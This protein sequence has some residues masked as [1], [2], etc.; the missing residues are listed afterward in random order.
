MEL[1]GESN[2]G[3]RALDASG[4]GRRKGIVPV[5]SC[6]LEQLPLKG[7]DAGSGPDAG[8]SRDFSESELQPRPQSH[9]QGESAWANRKYL[10]DPES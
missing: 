5:G 4:T 6:Y 10:L 3:G 2:L 1:V 8:A 9:P 7:E